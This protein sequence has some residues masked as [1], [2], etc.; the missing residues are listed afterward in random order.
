MRN[1]SNG[2]SLSA[3]LRGSASA[4]GTC[5]PCRLAHRSIRHPS[6]KPET[7]DGKPNPYRNRFIACLRPRS[8]ARKSVDVFPGNSNAGVV[9]SNVANFRSHSARSA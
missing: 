2:G 1:S 5:C 4:H 8:K 6:A 9:T 7:G 3:T